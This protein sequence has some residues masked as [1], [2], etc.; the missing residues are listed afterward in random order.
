VHDENVT[1]GREALLAATLRGQVKF[2]P[3]DSDALRSSAVFAVRQAGV[4]LH[5]RKVLHDLQRNGQRT[6]LHR[7]FV[8]LP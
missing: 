8:L 3:G 2:S 7:R 6:P 1:R 5:V 4:R